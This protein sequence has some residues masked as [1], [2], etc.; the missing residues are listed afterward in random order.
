[1]RWRILLLRKKEVI[2]TQMSE[3]GTQRV[4][5]LGLKGRN[6]GVQGTISLLPATEDTGLGMETSGFIYSLISIYTIDICLSTH[7]AV[8]PLPPETQPRMPP[9]PFSPLIQ[10]NQ[11]I[12]SPSDPSSQSMRLSPPI[13][14]EGRE[15]RNKKWES[16]S[17]RHQK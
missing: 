9:S 17:W 10:N 5:Y 3:L 2:F 15:K 4:P 6:G 14:P 7:P 16:F 8:R 11:P 12:Q 1:V 13:K